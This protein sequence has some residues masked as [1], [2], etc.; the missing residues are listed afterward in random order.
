MK[1]LLFRDKYNFLVPMGRT[2]F[3]TCR[4]ARTWPYQALCHA[5]QVQRPERAS[6]DD[7]RLSLDCINLFQARLQAISIL[8]Y[9]NAGNDILQNL[10]YDGLIEEL[11]DVL[12]VSDHRLTVREINNL[13]YVKLCATL[14]FFQ[15]LND[16]SGS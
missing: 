3:C 12:G 8:V 15:G 1:K 6:E 14:S 5:I 10:L 13:F 11:V 16:L 2:I 7:K 9:S 4:L